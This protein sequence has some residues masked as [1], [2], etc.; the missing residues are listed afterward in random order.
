MPHYRRPSTEGREF[1]TTP[2][3]FVGWIDDNG[4]WLSMEL[5]L[6][7]RVRLARENTERIISEWRKYL[8]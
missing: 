5:S 8:A 2:S 6:H 4:R 3:G 1:V 7:S